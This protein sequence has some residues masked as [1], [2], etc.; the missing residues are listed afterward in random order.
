MPALTM[1]TA[2]VVGVVYAGAA[3]FGD[4]PCPLSGIPSAVSIWHLGGRLLAGRQQ[5]GG[6]AE[7]FLADPEAPVAC[8]FS[9][10]RSF[11]YFPEN[12]FLSSLAVNGVKRQFTCRSLCPMYLF[13]FLS[14]PVSTTLYVF[15]RQDLQLIRE[16][17]RGGLLFTSMVLIITAD[18]PA[19]Y[20][21]GLL[22]A[23]G[24]V[25]FLGYGFASWLAI[26]QN[27]SRT[28]EHVTT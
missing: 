11:S 21:F 9:F 28:V 2:L 15:E 7:A 3:D 6:S 26:K 20:A 16:I 8:F 22:S 27:R 25:S 19:V 12:C 10:W 14:I 24:T 1:P 5:G 13:Q 17:I 23:S 18:L 4:A